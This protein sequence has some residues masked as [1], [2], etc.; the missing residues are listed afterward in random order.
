MLLQ[1]TNFCKTNIG[2][3]KVTKIRH[4]ERN[5]EDPYMFERVQLQEIQME[6]TNEQSEEL[7][8][9]R[10]KP[11]APKPEKFLVAK[12]ALTMSLITLVLFSIIIPNSILAIIHKY[13][14]DCGT[15]LWQYRIGAPFR[16][17]SHFLHQGLLLKKIDKI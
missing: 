7:T 16:I 15:Y 8:V 6:T 12:R 4:V 9:H 1:D 11:P 2:G 3:Q 10:I 14:G 5:I 17:I 13:S